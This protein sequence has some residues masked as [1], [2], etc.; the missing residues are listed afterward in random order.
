MNIG[1]SRAI[2]SVS[3]ILREEVKLLSTDHKPY[4][5]KEKERINKM[6]GHIQKCIY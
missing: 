2:L 1:D 3:E 4:L 6:G 5:K